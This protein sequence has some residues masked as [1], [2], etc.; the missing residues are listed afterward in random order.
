M[1][2]LRQRAIM[3]GYNISV[4]GIMEYVKPFVV[5][6]GLIALGKYTSRFVDPAIAPLI[7]GLPTGVIASFFLDSDK[8][9]KGYYS[10]YVYSSFVLFFVIAAIHLVGEYTAMS[11][12]LVSFLG[13]CV[14]GAISYVVI[15]A[16][17][18]S[19]KGKGRK[20]AGRQRGGGGG[21]RHLYQHDP[22][23]MRWTSIQP[24]SAHN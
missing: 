8:I 21:A 6:G 7:G 24:T 18:I 17:V 10:G 12:D 13:L 1:I 5:G 9:R 11:M 23:S 20:R 3:G 15:Q 4:Y 16:E 2:L 19:K 14:W 22:H